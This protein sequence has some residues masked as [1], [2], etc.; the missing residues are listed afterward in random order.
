MKSFFKWGMAQHAATRSVV[1]SYPLASI[2]WSLLC[3]AMMHPA[4]PTQG[5]FEPL[6]SPPPPHN[7]ILQATSPPAWKDTWVSRI[8]LLGKYIDLWGVILSDYGTKY[9]DVAD[10]VAGS[11]EEEGE[12][13]E[14]IGMRIGMKDKEKA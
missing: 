6:P 12:G 2:R 7:L 10:F 5:L 4:N 3:V 8:P 1:E 13:E 11:F 14:W 9:E